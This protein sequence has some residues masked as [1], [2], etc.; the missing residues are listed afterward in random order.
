MDRFLETQF[1]LQLANFIVFMSPVFLR[2]RR[3]VSTSDDKSLRVWEWNI[4]VGKIHILLLFLMSH[5]LLSLF[6]KNIFDWL[7]EG[8]HEVHCG[9]LHAF[10]ALRHPLSQW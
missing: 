1:L 6:W 8:G 2:N 3:F 9:P 10:N 4:P 7:F 5:I